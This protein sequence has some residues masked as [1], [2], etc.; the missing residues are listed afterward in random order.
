MDS[1][2]QAAESVQADVAQVKTRWAKVKDA[3]TNH[4]IPDVLQAYKKL[5]VIAF[6]AIFALP[7]AYQMAGSMGLLTID[8]VPDKFKWMVRACAIGG[9]YLRLVRQSAASGAPAAGK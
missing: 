2:Q 4:F 7:D 9:L 6:A 1:M 5:S 3:V 8:T